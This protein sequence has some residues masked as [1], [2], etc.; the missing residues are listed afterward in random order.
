MSKFCRFKTTARLVVGGAL[1]A[2]LAVPARADTNLVVAADGTSPY[3]TVQDAIM[4]VPSGSPTN[5][6]IIHIKPGTYKELVYLQREKRFFHL[7]GEK[8][9]TTIITYNLNANQIGTNGKPIG[10]FR[11]PTTQIDADDFTAENIT[12]ENS[13]GP[14]GQALAIRTDG[15]R[16]VFRNCRFIGWQDT[17][18]AN[19]GRQYFENCYIAGHV[20]FIFGAA[21][22]F[23]EKCHIRCLGDGYITAA[24]TP[25]DQPFGYVFSNCKITG[26]KPESRTFL[27][28]PWRIYA[29]TVFLNTEMSEVVRPEGWNNWKKPEAESTTFYA[30][31]HSTGPGAHPETRVKWAKQLTAEESKKYWWKT[32]CAARTTGSHEGEHF[33]LTPGKRSQRREGVILETSFCSLRFIS[34][35]VFDHKGQRAQTLGPLTR[36]DGRTSLGRLPRGTG[37]RCSRLFQSAK[38]GVILTDMLNGWSSIGGAGV[39]RTARGVGPGGI[40]VATTRTAREINRR[41]LLNLIRKH[42][43]ISRA[44][45]SRHSHLQR[46]T[47]SNITEQLIAER[48]VTMGGLG[49][50]PR[51][52][53]P[54]FLHF[55]GD[56]AAILGVDIRPKETTLAVSDLSMRFRT[57]ESIPTGRH[58]EQF[59]HALGGRISGLIKAHPRLSFEGIGVALPGRVDLASGKLVFAPNLPWGTLDLRGPLEQASGLTVEMENAANACALAEMWSGRHPGNVRHLFAVT[60]SEGVGVGMVLNGQLFRGTGGLAGEFGHVT[61]EPGGPPCRCGNNGCLEV[62]GSNTAALRYFAELAPK[63]RGKEPATAPDF[64][65]L[66]E[67]AEQGDPRARA[68]LERAAHYLGVGAAM[69]VSGLAPDVIVVVGEI[70]RAWERV[71]NIIKGVVSQQAPTRMNTRIVPSDPGT[72]PRLRGA[73]ALVLRKHFGEV[74]AV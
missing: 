20:D 5:H 53:K 40:Q 1:L 64:E 19:R 61:V 23:F 42:Q 2:A 17:I 18:L 63:R 73:M 36:R 13:A 51:G 50:L 15:D 26:D 6:V 21:T 44:E 8:A 72:Q 3:R 68:A 47:V 30:E 7:V 57:Q 9:E 65:G 35:R 46:S 62:C 33:D 11:T 54:T 66:L 45:L 10:T 58:P 25:E 24:S 12:F 49:E 29:S 16:L 41:V 70:T 43:P 52:R 34:Q 55:N 59:I 38:R 27:G 39:A 48:W 37:D 4:V 32:C 60:V 56:R 28:R 74:P 67:L 71:G 14:V 31:Y 69:L 22:C